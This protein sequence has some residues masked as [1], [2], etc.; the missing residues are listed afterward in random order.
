M[1]LVCPNRVCCVCRVVLVF[2][3]LDLEPA[4]SESEAL[5]KIRKIANKNMV[6]VVVVVVVLSLV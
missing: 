2:Q 4:L 6:G 1:C 3:P 5:A